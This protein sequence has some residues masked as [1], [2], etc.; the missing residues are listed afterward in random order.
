APQLG[1]NRRRRRP[2]ARGRLAAS[3]DAR[4]PLTPK[5]ASLWR[6]L[7]RRSRLDAELDE[8][9]RG[10]LDALTARKIREGLDPAA[11]RRAASVEMGGVELVVEET[12]SARIGIGVETTLRDVR[13]AW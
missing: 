3:E 5:F 13:Y 9:V 12:R 1:S 4:V 8:E 7:F 11:A 6:T 10:Y 2:G